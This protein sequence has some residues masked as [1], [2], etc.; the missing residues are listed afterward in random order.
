MHPHS[1]SRNI[2]KGRQK[3]C[4]HTYLIVVILNGFTYNKFVCIADI[5][6]IVW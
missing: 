4:V 3:F 2:T 1:A 5:V 6:C